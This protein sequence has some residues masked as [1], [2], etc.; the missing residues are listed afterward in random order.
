MFCLFIYWQKRDAST[1]EKSLEEDKDFGYKKS[2]LSAIQV[3]TYFQVFL[4]INQ[5]NYLVILLSSIMV[6]TAI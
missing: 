5:H 2:L 1:A 4:L 6:F 3:V